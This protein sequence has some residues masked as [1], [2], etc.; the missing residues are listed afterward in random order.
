MDVADGRREVL[1]GPREA[2]ERVL[3]RAPVSRRSVLAGMAACGALVLISL[4]FT[5]AA[6]DSP[7]P[8]T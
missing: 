7:L 1:S 5:L 3:R 4:W 8:A 6:P 2:A